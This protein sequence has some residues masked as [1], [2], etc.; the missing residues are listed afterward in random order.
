MKRSFDM[1]GRKPNR[2]VE[3]IALVLPQKPSWEFFDLFDAIH[4]N[5]RTKCRAGT[6]EDMLR[7]RVHEQLQ[8]L[9]LKGFVRKIGKEYHPVS[10]RLATL[11]GSSTE[12][13]AEPPEKPPAGETC[14]GSDPQRLKQP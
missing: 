5:L 14:D 1:R 6:G 10:A 4:S 12:R 9:V 3:E 13:V 2:V 7:L 8:R 11:V